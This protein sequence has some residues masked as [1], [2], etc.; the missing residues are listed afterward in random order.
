MADAFIRRDIVHP[1]YRH[2]ASSAIA[3]GLI[4]AIAGEIAGF[5]ALLTGPT[6]QTIPVVDAGLMALAATA[7]LPRLAELH[8]V[9]HRDIARRFMYRI[10]PAG[11]GGVGIIVST[12]HIPTVP[13]LVLILMVAIT[14]GGALVH[15]FT[16]ARTQWRVEKRKNLEK[17]NAVRTD[18]RLAED[19]LDKARAAAARGDRS[20]ATVAM[21]ETQQAIDRAERRWSESA[22]PSIPTVDPSHRADR[23]A[24]S[25]M[26]RTRLGAHWLLA[27]VA[28]A[29][30][31]V[32]VDRLW[33]R[34]R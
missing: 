23:D 11:I 27:S 21:G 29:A 4:F 18:V 32:A 17:R 15:A 31:A 34:R 8:V 22:E 16:D 25:P 9:R 26:P 10:L 2:F 5:Q 7:L 13:R 30:A 3:V 6:R 28:T 12:T 24:P 14:F 20:E 1:V 33:R 19:A